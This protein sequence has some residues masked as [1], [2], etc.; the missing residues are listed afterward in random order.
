M[1]QSR[2]NWLIMMGVVV[3]PAVA[4][5]TQQTAFPCAESDFGFVVHHR[6]RRR[7]RLRLGATACGRGSRQFAL[8][9]R[10]FWRGVIAVANEHY[11]ILG[12]GYGAFFSNRGG[13]QWLDPYLGYW[14][15]RPNHAHNGYLNLWADLGRLWLLT[16]VLLLTTTSVQLLRRVVSQPRGPYGSLSARSCSCFS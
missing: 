14:T 12:A 2:S 13:V 11:P 15:I 6:L 9:A 10:E 7:G 5:F 8:G 1:A 4:T 16:L 3:S